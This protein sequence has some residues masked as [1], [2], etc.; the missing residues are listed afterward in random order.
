MGLNRW[1]YRDNAP[2]PTSNATAATFRGDLLTVFIAHTTSQSQA[3][4]QGS[5]SSII[6]ATPR[7]GIVGCAVVLDVAKIDWGFRFGRSFFVVV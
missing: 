4:L 6:G 3:F 2:L 7:V 5:S 1:L